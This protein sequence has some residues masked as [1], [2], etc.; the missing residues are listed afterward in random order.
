MEHDGFY[1]KINK[2]I[3]GKRYYVCATPN[4]YCKGTLIQLE[5]GTII[6]NKDHTHLAYGPTFNKQQLIKRLRTTLI[7][8]S[9][10]E[11]KALKVIYDEE[12]VRNQEAALNYS[13]P[14]QSLICGRPE[15]VFVQHYH[16]HY[17][18]WANI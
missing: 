15:E 14:Q 3:G 9:K 4:V 8:R 1:Y 2:T 17:G 10:T 16:P 18:S 5:N 7:E 11:T 12:S 6:P 13:W